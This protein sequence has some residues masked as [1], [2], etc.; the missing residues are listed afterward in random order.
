MNAQ[1]DGRNKIPSIAQVTNSRFLL[2]FSC[3]TSGLR[4]VSTSQERSEGGVSLL[5]SCQQFSGGKGSGRLDVLLLGI[6]GEVTDRRLLLKE[7][8]TKGL[9]ARIHKYVHCCF[10]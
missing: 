2:P 9:G 6:K 8:T 5:A 4:E 3:V 10:K 7:M 1:S